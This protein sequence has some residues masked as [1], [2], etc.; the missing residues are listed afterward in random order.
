MRVFLK[1]IK[2]EGQ[3]VPTEPLLPGTEG[4]EPFALRK[5]VYVSEKG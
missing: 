3:E 4:I 1:E 2:I 5:V